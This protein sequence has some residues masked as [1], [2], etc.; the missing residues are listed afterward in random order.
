VGKNMK[1]TTKTVEIC[2][3]TKNMG[4]SIEPNEKPKPEKH[5]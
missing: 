2:I 5:T 4:G 1:F 3:K